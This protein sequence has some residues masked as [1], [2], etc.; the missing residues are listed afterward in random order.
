MFSFRDKCNTLDIFVLIKDRT[1]GKRGE[2]ERNEGDGSNNDDSDGVY[3]PA[4]RVK[5]MKKSESVGEAK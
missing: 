5:Y 3:L 1:N 4:I 2:L